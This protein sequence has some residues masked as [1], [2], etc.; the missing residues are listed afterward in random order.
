MLVLNY[1]RSQALKT[2]DMKALEQFG[3]SVGVLT[4]GAVQLLLF[5][6]TFQPFNRPDCMHEVRYLLRFPVCWVTLMQLVVI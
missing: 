2:V 1:Q 5:L 6:E 3:I 4:N